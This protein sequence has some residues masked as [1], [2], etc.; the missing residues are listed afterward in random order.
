LI[1]KFCKAH[2]PSLI[3]RAKELQ[4]EACEIVRQC[5]NNDEYRVFWDDTN[6]FTRHFREAGEQEGS[7][8][9]R[10]QAPTLTPQQYQQALEVG[11][12]QS[13]SASDLGIVDP[14][15][16]GPQELFSTD[17]QGQMPIYPAMAP[18]GYDLGLDNSGSTHG[19]HPSATEWA[20]NGLATFPQFSDPDYWNDRRYWNFVDTTL[21]DDF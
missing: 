15:V 16:W 4:P 11:V 12:Q 7:Q 10:P 9:H 18:D 6:I 17:Q 2:R 13:N 20:T 5:F 8:H 21:M 1:W 3:E 14:N 19:V